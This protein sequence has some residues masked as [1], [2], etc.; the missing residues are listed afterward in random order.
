MRTHTHT[1]THTA[2]TVWAAVSP[3]DCPQEHCRDMILTY[4]LHILT[5]QHNTIMFIGDSSCIGVISCSINQS[6]NQSMIEC[7]NPACA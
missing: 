6:I 7:N 4:T 1:H 2:P 3:S 5:R